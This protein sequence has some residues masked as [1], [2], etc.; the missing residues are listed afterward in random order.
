MGAFLN[1]F[2]SNFP[3]T[4][5]TS[6]FYLLMSHV[7][8]KFSNRRVKGFEVHPRIIIKELIFQ[9]FNYFITWFYNDSFWYANDAHTNQLEVLMN[10]IMAYCETRVTKS[11][12]SLA[13][14]SKPLSSSLSV[15]H[16]YEEQ[17]DLLS[18]LVLW[19]S[20]LRILWYR[21]RP[22]LL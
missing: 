14:F 15:I 3:M 4:L 5:I 21:W 1:Q 6:N 2:L 17:S 22:I 11:M 20:C 12:Q 9:L 10:I 19:V 8:V 16:Q 13:S 7:L 18:L